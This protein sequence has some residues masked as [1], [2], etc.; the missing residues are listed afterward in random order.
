MAN[1]TTNN[2]YKNTH[3]PGDVSVSR[4]VNIGGTLTQQGS[5]HI[6]GSVKI[7]GWLDAKNI[8][9]DLVNKGLFENEEGLKKALPKP[10]S[11]WYA[12]VLDRS[13]NETFKPKVYLV[14]SGEWHFTEQYFDGIDIDYD[15][16]NDLSEA[17]DNLQND[18]D[19]IKSHIDISL[20]SCSDFTD[21]DF[22]VGD[23]GVA[24]YVN[25][26]KNMAYIKSD[27]YRCFWLK[28]NEGDV[29]S[30]Y[31]LGYSDNVSIG[32]SAN[33][34][35][36]DFQSLVAD[37]GHKLRTATAESDGYFFVGLIYK[38]EQGTLFDN[39]VW[40]VAKSDFKT[41]D[42]D[43]SDAIS[44]FYG[45]AVG[46]IGDTVTITGPT[47]QTSLVFEVHKGDTV[48][49]VVRQY[50]DTAAVSFSTDMPQVGSEVLILDNGDQTLNKNVT[51]IAP[52]D[53]YIMLTYL[54]QF[55][56]G[57]SDIKMV[58]SK[59]AYNDRRIAALE[60]TVE[61]HTKKI[62][63]LDSRNFIHFTP[64]PMPSGNDMANWSGN[65]VIENIYEPL[66]QQYPQ[67]ITRRS[68]GK[69][70]SGSYDIW[71]YEFNN[72]V[73]EWFDIADKDYFIS[74]IIQPGTNGLTERQCGIK[75]ST[76]DNVFSTIEHKSVYFLLNPSPRVLEKETSREEMTYNEEIY[77][78]FTFDKK[79]NLNS[80]GGIE[81]WWTKESKTFDQH[82]MIISGIHADEISGYI[83]TGLA[84]KYMIEHHEENPTLDYIFNHVKLSVVPIVNV[85]GA[86]QSQKVRNNY[87]NINL[88]DWSKNTEEHQAIN[89]YVETV[90]NELS[91]FLDFHTSEFWADYGFVYAVT[92][93]HSPLYPAI[94]ATANYLCRHWFPQLPP[95]NWNIGGKEDS[96]AGSI[97]AH[98]YMNNNYGITGAVVESCGLDLMKYGICE[99]WS[100]KYM[101]YVVENYLN[102]II[103]TCGIRIKNNSKA[104]IIS[105][106]FDKHTMT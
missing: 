12:L 39:K 34:T 35:I 48:Q 75:K 38:D 14:K 56:D 10:K 61:N 95:Y 96:T 40:I 82:G 3:F 23:M 60:N 26:L 6:K 28:V 57:I 93:P 73:D 104:I 103:A 36:D 80:N 15:Y 24:A 84:L 11:G 83:G 74:A 7:D 20:Y 101:T 59:S 71:L 52:A 99:K 81:V 64:A 43:E 102:F 69:D 16:Y 58:S 54:N 98:I 42:L 51:G 4:N 106:V 92:V 94:V 30:T 13:D 8:K 85:W 25:P 53:G 105:D 18:V 27:Y 46:N 47:G 79:I 63:C 67:Y 49:A 77:Y 31:T 55:T 21:K 41:I 86:N 87:N 100:A 66:R 62:D 89:R 68:L 45:N 19:D 37:N 88:S 17:V 91:F 1:D 22:N 44:R 2:G 33:K 65:D 78:I 29:L 50:G 70:T 97:N 72:S 9:G 90:K 76:F 32:F 5:A